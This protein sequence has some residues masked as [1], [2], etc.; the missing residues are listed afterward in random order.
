MKF[1]TKSI[2]GLLSTFFIVGVGYSTEIYEPTVE[3]NEFRKAVKGLCGCHTTPEEADRWEKKIRKLEKDNPDFKLLHNHV[4]TCDCQKTGTIG[5]EVCAGCLS[6]LGCHDYAYYIIA[7]EQCPGGELKT[8]A[9]KEGSPQGS[10]DWSDFEIVENPEDSHLVFYP[11]GNHFGIYRGN[12][13]VESTLGLRVLLHKLFQ[14][15]PSYGDTVEFYK[16][17]PLT[18]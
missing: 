11:E 8:T 1:F 5:G 9:I 2:A 6:L 3:S 12:G 10:F 14:V 16:F 15:P 17:V 13:V 7:M 4:D 18:E